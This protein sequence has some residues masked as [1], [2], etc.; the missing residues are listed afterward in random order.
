MGMQQPEKLVLQL[1]WLLA[2]P[3]LTHSS[4]VAEMMAAAAAGCVMDHLEVGEVQLREEAE[5]GLEE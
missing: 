2:L 3:K 4:W 1:E 5:V